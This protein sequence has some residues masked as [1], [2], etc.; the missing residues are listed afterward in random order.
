M[1]LKSRYPLLCPESESSGDE[2]IENGSLKAQADGDEEERSPSLLSCAEP[3]SSGDDARAI[4]SKH[5]H[6][7]RKRSR[8]GL[9]ILKKI[10]G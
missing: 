1:I 2:E 9:S 6:M 5:C 8:G 10:S 4:L 7:A 3:E